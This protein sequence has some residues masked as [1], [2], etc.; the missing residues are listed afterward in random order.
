LRPDLSEN[1]FLPV[2][3]R[4]EASSGN[5]LA[6]K[7]LG[8]KGGNWRPNKNHRKNPVV[9][10]T[11]NFRLQTSGNIILQILCLLTVE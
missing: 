11:S 7:R 2:G 8:A 5:A 3:K 9:D 4:Q 10:K 6:K 1:P